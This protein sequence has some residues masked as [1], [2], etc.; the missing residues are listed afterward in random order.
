M[1]SSPARK[2]A[3]LPPRYSIRISFGASV[4]TLLCDGRTVAQRPSRAALVSL[5]WEHS[6]AVGPSSVGRH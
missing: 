5:A 2:A 4:W 3:M 6:R 1:R